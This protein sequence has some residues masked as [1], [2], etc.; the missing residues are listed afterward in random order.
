MKYPDGRVPLLSGGP[1]KSKYSFEQLHFH[2]GLKNNEGSEH[3]IDGRY[4]SMEMHA[5][6]RNTKYDQISDATSYRNGLAV[7]GFLFE[8]R[9]T[10]K[11]T[12]IC[13]KIN[14]SWFPHSLTV[15]C[16][17]PRLTRSA[18][19]RT[20]TS[21]GRWAPPLRYAACPLASGWRTLSSRCSRS[22]SRT[23]AVWQRHR[24]VRRSVGWW[25]G[26]RWRFL[27][28]TWV[29]WFDWRRFLLEF[30]LAGNYFYIYSSLS[31][32]RA[33]DCI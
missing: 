26:T 5:L 29:F 3:T 22:L 30:I 33:D 24:A 25:L 28:T 13:K 15:L 19:W 12:A 17:C 1:L 4:S 23:R 8:V 7:L 20:W 18:F 9:W 31:L 2:W 32:P 6:F 27:E 14:Y 10:G 21:C 11:L 16:R